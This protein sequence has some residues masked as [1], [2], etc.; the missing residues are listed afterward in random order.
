MMA[1]NIEE[2]NEETLEVDLHHH[3]ATADVISSQIIIIVMADT[4]VTIQ[5]VH[6]VHSLHQHLAMKKA[7][8]ARFDT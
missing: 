2:K 7:T 5:D 3:H 6:V 4:A 1:T 8:L